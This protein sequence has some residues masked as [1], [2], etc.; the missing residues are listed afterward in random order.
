MGRT[1]VRGSIM[2]TEYT[3]EC[4]ICD[5]VSVVRVPYENEVPRHCPMCGADG[6]FETGYSFNLSD[7][8]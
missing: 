6:E 5:I 4:P 8:E 1:R 3:I 7:E 2:D